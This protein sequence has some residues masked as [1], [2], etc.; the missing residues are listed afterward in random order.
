M[1]NILTGFRI[2]CALALI[3]CPT[4]SAWF[5][6]FYLL[7]GISDVLDGIAARRL[8]QETKFGAKLDTAADAVFAGVVL[9]QWF[10]AFPVPTWLIVWTMVI[11]VIKC[12][13]L[14]VGFITA[15]RFLAEHTVLNK[16]CGILLF[17][18]PLSSRLLPRQAT[19]GWMILTCTAATAAAVQEGCYIRTG[20]EVD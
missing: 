11:A 16:I 20:K 14:T 4:F 15:K 13:N 17:G 10:R 18:I 7:G 9:I 6:G 8:G 12:V 19:I 2:L 1:A 3:F 5:Y